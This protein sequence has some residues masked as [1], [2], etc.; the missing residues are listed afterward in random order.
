VRYTLVGAGIK[1]DTADG[2]PLIV[3]T[4]VQSEAAVLGGYALTTAGETIGIAQAPQYE[5]RKI[6]SD[7]P[8][9]QGGAHTLMIT[10]DDLLPNDTWHDLSRA[11]G[12]YYTV[13]AQMAR[14]ATCL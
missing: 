8:D 12:F 6:G 9:A 11:A 1:I 13:M 2:S 10:S 14:S 4:Q 7:N 3:I 5:N